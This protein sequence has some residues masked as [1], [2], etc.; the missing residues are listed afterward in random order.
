MSDFEELL[1]QL[2][3]DLD[4]RSLGYFR[5]S[6]KAVEEYVATL[7]QENAQLKRTIADDEM[8]SGLLNQCAELRRERDEAQSVS[9]EIGKQYRE[10][11]D[12]QATLR[13]RIETVEGWLVQFEW[14]VRVPGTGIPYCLVCQRTKR[15][16]HAPDCELAKALRKE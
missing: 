14:G 12:A 13:Q 16:G 4:V 7:Q 3:N 8:F 15:A 1:D 10:L 11:A 9:R 2:I 5:K 6:R